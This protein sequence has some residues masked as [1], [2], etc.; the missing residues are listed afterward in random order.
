MRPVPRE[1]GE[2]IL[3]TFLAI[4]PDFLDEQCEARCPRC[5]ETFTYRKREGSNQPKFCVTCAKY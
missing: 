1:I 4:W 3:A 5:C 2:T